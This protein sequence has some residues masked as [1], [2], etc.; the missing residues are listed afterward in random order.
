MARFDWDDD[1]RVN[2]RKVE[3]AVTQLKKDGFPVTSEG[4]KALYLTY[5]GF[6]PEQ[7]VQ[8]DEI[9]EDKPKRSK[10]A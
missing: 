2:E 7:D 9:E 5:G 10:K 4:V 6:L 8:E 1:T 3:R